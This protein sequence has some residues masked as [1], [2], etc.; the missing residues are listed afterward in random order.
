VD[1]K[2]QKTTP[3]NTAQTNALE[4]PLKLTAGTIVQAVL[5]HPEGCQGLAY[6][7]IYRG[8]HQVYPS[9]PEEAYNGNAVPAIF[10]DNYELETPAELTLK[11]WNLDDTYEH[12]VY[13]R[14]TV[15]RPVLTLF[16]EKILNI[17]SSVIT[18]LTGRRLTI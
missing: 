12:T 7:A 3:A 10:T 18:L 2:Y 16:E 8:G 14:I 17:L 9:N 13:V 15:L 4:T 11:T 5:F 1:Y 6:A